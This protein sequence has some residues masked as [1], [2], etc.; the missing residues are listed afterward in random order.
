MIKETLYKLIEKQL[1]LDAGSVDPTM[2]LVNDLGADSID[3][4]EIIMGI[5]KA[6]KISIEQKDYENC[7]TIGQIQELIT[8]KIP[9]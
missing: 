9:V 1:G 2:N 8:E 7:T 6:F 3:V 4:V 5:E